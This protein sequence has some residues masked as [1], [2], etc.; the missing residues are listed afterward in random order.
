MVS[1]VLKMTSE[2]LV[3]TLARFHQEFA[4]DAEYQKLR[5]VFPPDWPM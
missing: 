3:A 1:S 4:D 5:A 2:E